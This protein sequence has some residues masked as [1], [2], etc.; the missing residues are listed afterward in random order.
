LVELGVD[1]VADS[2]LPVARRGVGDGA[3]VGRHSGEQVTGGG[4][5]VDLGAGG[6]EEVFEDGGEVPVLGELGEQE[7]DQFV[8]D[9]EVVGA[10]DLGGWRRR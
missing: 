4:F 10:G 1:A 8:A 7:A 9:D 2:G 5:E 3:E 6:V